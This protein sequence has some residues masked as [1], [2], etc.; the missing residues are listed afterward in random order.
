MFGSVE[1]ASQTITTT[2]T[3]T[4]PAKKPRSDR[5]VGGL[6]LA[7]FTALYLL[8]S[9]GHLYSPDGE[10]A[11]RM[12]RS[13]TIDPQHQYLIQNR[14]M[15]S[16]W[17]IMVPLLSQ[18]FIVLGEPLANA[19]PQKDHVTVDGHDFTLGIF[20][21]H[22]L[23]E[24]A[25][26]AGPDGPGV[27]DTYVR[28]DLPGT[29]S[30]ALEIISYL[31]YSENI[32]Q[33]AVVAD[34]TL[35]DASGSSVTLPLRAGV[36]TAEWSRGRA[37]PPIKHRM[38]RVAAIWSGNTS[39]RSYYT[40]I[41]FGRTLDPTR[42]QIHYVYGSARLYVQSMALVNGQTGTFQTIPSDFATWSPRENDEYFALIFYGAYNAFVTALGCLLLFATARL[43]GY[44]QVVSAVATL[45]YGLATLAWPYSKYDFTEPTLTLLTLASIYLIFRWGQ[46]RRN[47]LLVGAG[48]LALMAAVT[49]YVAAI[50]IPVMVLQIVVLYWENCPSVTKLR[51]LFRPLLS[52][53][54]PFLIV[55]APAI[56]YLRQHFGYYPSIFEAWAGVQRGWLPLPML[57]GLRGLLFSPGKSFFLFS[58]PAI[59]AVLSTFS[60]V[61]RHGVRSVALLGIILIYFTVYS[62]KVA[63]DA[64]AGWGPRYQV[65]ILPLVVLLAAPLIK[66]AIEDRHRWAMYALVATF[67]LGVGIQMLAIP[68]NFNYYLGLFRFEVVTQM[69]DKG[70][71]YGGGDYFPYAAGLSDHN[72]ITATVWAW[73]FSPILAHAWLLTADVLHLGRPYLQPLEYKVLGMPP[74]RMM[75]IDILP[76]HPGDGLGLD[77]WSTILFTDF[78][79]NTGL[80][81]GAFAVLLVLETAVVAF[82]AKL[83][84]LLTGRSSF[85]SRTM[86]AWL[87]CATVIFL[88]FDGIHFLL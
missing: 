37:S 55:A 58:P 60:F 54:V 80:L 51:G 14:R 39:G 52:F 31:S 22:S 30:T 28:T 61:R 77:F 64:G 59:L 73:P 76:Q 32:P 13:L 81:M 71:Q 33:D 9:S 75:G 62:K 49:K 25:P 78:P 38:A 4:A 72:S 23:P 20:R 85:R 47:L 17:G 53:G 63:W 50:L 6:L 24:D 15:L 34:V 88:L 7:F 66:K 10:F 36:E 16:Q 65:V 79:S 19:M 74:W 42:L 44:S 56:Y 57:I 70:A 1:T 45:V 69:P 86:Q 43:L 83:V 41:P 84:A 11:F 46:S 12:A 8:T 67:V 18:P 5:Y 82:G 40:E 21:T 48:I 26:T 27:S 35:T 2:T 68:K 29:P 87:V 3:Q